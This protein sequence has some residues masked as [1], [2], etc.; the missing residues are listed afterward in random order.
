MSNTLPAPTN[1]AEG[2]AAAERAAYISGLRKL[3]NI[4]EDNPTFPLPYTGRKE[5]AI[6]WIELFDDVRDR[7]A[8]FA[9]V[10]P[11]PVVKAVRGNNLDLTARIDGLHVLMIAERDEVCTRT[12]V[13]VEEIEVSE[14]DPAAVAALPLVTRI[15]KR[16]IV[17]WECAPLLGGA[18][19]A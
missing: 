3:A 2:R 10:M 13:G 19:D 8:A 17:K 5:S 9:Q 16:D 18:D 7:A 4:L 1:T 12:V 15:E 11:R 14:P 6:R